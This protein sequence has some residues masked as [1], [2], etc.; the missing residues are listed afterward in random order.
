M[1]AATAA[2]IG[3]AGPMSASPVTASNSAPLGNSTARG[4]SAGAGADSPV[5][6]DTAGRE[7]KGSY[8]A[9]QVAGRGDSVAFAKAMKGPAPAKVDA[10]RAA[11][12]PSALVDIDPLTGTPANVASL[13][14]FLTR[15][16]SDDA[17]QVAM[18]YIRSNLAA[19]GLTRAD[20]GTFQLHSRYVD[21]AGTT[22]LAW[23]QQ[24]RGV[25]VFGNGLEA[26]VTRRGELISVQGS[27]ISGLNTLAA[28]PS[29]TPLLSAGSARSAAAKD[30]GGAADASASL[31][32]SQAAGT[33]R[34]SNGDQA[35]L[36][37]F[38]TPS[39]LRLGWSTYTQAGD[40]LDYTH[41]VDARSGDVLYRRDLV[42]HAEGDAEVYDNYPGAARGG[43]P[44]VVNFYRKG[45]LPRRA[46]FLAGPNVAAWADV[47]DDNR[48]DE[49][50]RTPVPGTD[51]RAQFDLVSF[52]RTNNLCS[53]EFICTWNANKRYSWR[54]NK[55]ADVTNAFYLANNFHDYLER[56]P[57]GFTNR[58]GNFE[59]SD[60]DSVLL[61]AL[62]G[63]NTDRG[64]PDGNHIDNANMSTPPDGIAP[65]MQMYLWHT[66]RTPNS[67]D[68]FLPVSGA[69]DASILYHEYTHGLSNR[70]V[71]DAQG[72][73]TL[74][75]IQSGAMGEA[76]SDYYALDYLELRGFERDTLPRDGQ[77][78]IAKYVTGDKFP[79]RTMAVDC[80]RRSTVKW[81]TQIT[82]DKG[83]YTYG[84]FATI[85]GSP[86]VHAGGEVWTQTMWDIRERFGHRIAAM[87]I[88][89]GMELSRN[90]PTMLDMRNAMIQAD[91]VVY[92]GNH[93]DA[94]WKIFARRGFGWYAGSLD[95]GDVQPAED[96]HRPPAVIRGTGTL[97]GL[98]LDRNS[99]EPLTGA[100]V[101]ISGHPGYSDRVDAD[102]V[103]VIPGVRPG[104]YKRVILIADGYEI[105]S[106]R[107]RVTTSDQGTREDFTARRDWAA[108]SGG[109]R[110]AAFDPPD[111][112]AFGCGPVG[113]ID[114]S[115]G[116]G[117][118]SDTFGD[119]ATD[120]YPD[121]KS[122]V[123]RLPE[124]ITLNA[125]SGR[126]SAFKIDPTATCG[127]PG[128]AS[129]GD[130][131]IHV[132]A[133]ADG[134]WTR[135]AS[136]RGEANWLP[137][138]QFTNVAANA[139]VAGVRYVRF[140]IRT[141]QVPDFDTTCPDGPYAGCV[142]MD[143]TELEVF[144]T[145]AT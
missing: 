120:P 64:F 38:A 78:R 12:G 141:P 49:S 2:T 14:G 140:T 79:F 40:T 26:H 119:E 102:G 41:V 77:I 111:Y 134:P 20:L 104:P 17:R 46:E 45:W 130:F 54:V 126:N 39:G 105:V 92:S 52:N 32:D 66:P 48:A 37:W 33:S 99:G 43:D 144:G 106:K 76:W 15:S 65:T 123:V 3:F 86:G 31:R 51:R 19:L 5:R 44:R 7:R 23:T 133:D 55:K 28:G 113:A 9:R 145:P 87:L 71:V 89:R 50:E 29:A 122:I 34:W 56:A 63:A 59:R 137:R 18:R 101:T 136:R 95:S 4:D 80:D 53:R 142:F 135:V 84:D 24:A 21:V 72:N 70:L 36:V 10:L 62:D 108:F 138:Y 25:T 112:S 93:T 83:G 1:A 42:S 74:N 67:V 61:H 128:S 117:W 116:T 98:A 124:T 91:Q 75:G 118:G 109:G 139:P 30:V 97:F 143:L 22:H 125:G 85:G 94:L 132:S 60:G 103:Y 13:D 110:I 73:S 68:P 47:D 82:G 81:C 88:T 121:P 35:Q 16:S 131:T 69:F 57:I 114:L 115:Q 11:I 8:D 27:P 100:R 6:S 90:D 58:A 96:F 127:D 107:I 129:T